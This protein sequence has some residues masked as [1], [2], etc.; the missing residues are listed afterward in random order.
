MSILHP[1]PPLSGVADAA[2]GCPLI[3][4]FGRPSAV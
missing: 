3:D 4:S 1:P 2:R